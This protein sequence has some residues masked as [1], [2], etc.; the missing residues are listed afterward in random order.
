[1]AVK[2]VGPPVFPTLRDTTSSLVER[3]R[4]SASLLIDISQLA[5]ILTNAINS[6][7]IKMFLFMVNSYPFF[8]QHEII[9]GTT[10]P[11]LSIK[12]VYSRIN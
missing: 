3:L 7:T 4:D 8:I 11:H 9:V 12:I 6:T 2:L 1:V 5:N 10:L